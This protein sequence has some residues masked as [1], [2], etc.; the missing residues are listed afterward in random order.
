MA[1]LN[2]VLACVRACV[3]MW[4]RGP[5][6]GCL[7]VRAGVCLLPCVFVFVRLCARTKLRFCFVFDYFSRNL[8][9]TVDDPGCGLGPLIA[10]RC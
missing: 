6:R 4:L 2:R 1:V 9:E 8:Q 10:Y 3:V 7:C 5:A